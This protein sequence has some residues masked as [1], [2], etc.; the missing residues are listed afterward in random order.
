[1]LSIV[2]AYDYFDHSKEPSFHSWSRPA[3]K[4][5]RNDRVLRIMEV[6]LVMFMSIGVGIR[7]TISISKTMKMMASKK[8][9]NEKGIRAV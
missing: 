1:M 8:N 2:I 7:S 9:R 4:I 3:I 6:V 5:I